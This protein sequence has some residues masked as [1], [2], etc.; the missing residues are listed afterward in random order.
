MCSK[1]N[2]PTHWLVFG[3]NPRS[4]DGAIC[5]SKGRPYVP[6]GRLFLVRYAWRHKR[7]KADLFLKMV[8]FCWTFFIW[9]YFRVRLS[10]Q[11]FLSKTWARP[12]QIL[13]WLYQVP[14]NNVKILSKSQ[15]SSKTSLMCFGFSP[16]SPV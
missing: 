5:I 15:V 1:L 13:W 3:V 2:E 8:N 4:L 10:N 12:K 11:H 6:T 16:S 7:K 14:P 9:K